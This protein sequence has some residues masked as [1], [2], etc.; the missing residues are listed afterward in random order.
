ME[1]ALYLRL[2]EEDRDRGESPSQSIQNQELMLREYAARQ[3]W[4]VAAVYNDEDFSGADRSRPAFNRLLA[5]GAAGQF[6]VVL[7]K[8]LS[9]FTRLYAQQEEL[10]HERFPQWG[11]RFVSLVD[12]VDTRERANKKSRQIHA[13][14]N[15]WYLEDLSENIRRTF[16]A[17]MQAGQYLGAIAPYGYQKA[18]ADRHRLAVDEE[19]AAV[20]RRIYREFLAGRGLSAIARALTAAG[21]PT[22]YAY[23]QARGEA[24]RLPHVKGGWAATTVR[25]I[26]TNPV[27]RG[28]LAQ[29]RETTRSYKDKTRVRRPPEAWVVVED[30]HPAL[31]SPAEFAA[32]QA[33]LEARQKRRAGKKK[34][35]GP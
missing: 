23:K 11:L 29:G 21:V 28:A 24:L 18:A 25:K 33:E 3:G 13:L 14:V 15:E 27:Y 19:A 4:H 10:L 32:V 34:A 22:P 26:L 6:E 16:L 8:S 17:K 2:S 35:D 7:C 30:T 9:R 5:D 1:A 20:V 12:G 31:V